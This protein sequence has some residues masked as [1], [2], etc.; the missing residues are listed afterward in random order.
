MR[1]KRFP[2]SISILHFLLFILAVSAIR[3]FAQQGKVTDI[4]LPEFNPTLSGYKNNALVK[5]EKVGPQKKEM[6]VFWKKDEPKYN[7]V[8]A[9]GGLIRGRGVSIGANGEKICKGET[10]IA[11]DGNSQFVGNLDYQDSIYTFLGKVRLMNHTFISDEKAPLVF[12]M[13]KNK[14]FVYVS[15]KGSVETPKGAKIA[16]PPIAN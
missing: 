1:F 9:Q 16:I 2:V 12:K 15:G 14:G 6:T 10:H 13:V 11:I 3:G 7:L 5:M 8:A 4:V